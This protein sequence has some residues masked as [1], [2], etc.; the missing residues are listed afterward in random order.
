[1]KTYYEWEEE[2]FLRQPQTNE[3]LGQHF[4]NTFIKASIPELFYADTPSARLM[5]HQWLID[6][7][8]WPYVPQYTNSMKENVDVAVQSH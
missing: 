7:S 2:W 8:Y 4:A 6:N 3:R 5:I 1:M